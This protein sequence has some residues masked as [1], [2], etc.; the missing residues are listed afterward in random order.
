MERTLLNEEVD[1]IQNKLRSDLT[2]KMGYK[3][4]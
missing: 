2:N 4:R 3:L 1:L